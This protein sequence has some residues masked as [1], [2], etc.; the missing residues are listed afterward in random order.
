M[1][2]DRIDRADE[3]IHSMT[4]ITVVL[5]KDQFTE[6]QSG[7]RLALHQ[8]QLHR[9]WKKRFWRSDCESVSRRVVSLDGETDV[10]SNLS[11]QITDLVEPL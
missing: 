8:L 1:V 10:K 5:V 3:K 4:N 6:G 11:Y 7:Q 9:F 2:E